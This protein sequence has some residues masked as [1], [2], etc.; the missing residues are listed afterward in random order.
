MPASV[1]DRLFKRLDRPQSFPLRKLS[2]QK[3]DSLTFE[4]KW[5]S[6]K[7]AGTGTGT[8]TE[9]ETETGTETRGLRVRMRSMKH[10]LDLGCKHGWIR[11]RYDSHSRQ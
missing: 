8:G 11:T 7:D 5:T 2:Y 9:T 1:L 10:A 6:L 4:G 3:N